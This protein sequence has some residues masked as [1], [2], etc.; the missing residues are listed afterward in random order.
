MLGPGRGHVHR[1][2]VQVKVN[3]GWAAGE[4]KRWLTA[5]LNALWKFSKNP[6]PPPSFTTT[7]DFWI[8]P[9]QTGSHSTPFSKTTYPT[10]LFHHSASSHSNPVYYEFM[11]CFYLNKQFNTRIT[12]VILRLSPYPRGRRERRCACWRTAPSLGPSGAPCA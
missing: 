10:W 12:N 1:R 7:K 11:F 9:T 5:H 3:S 2:L 6:S 4:D 8:L